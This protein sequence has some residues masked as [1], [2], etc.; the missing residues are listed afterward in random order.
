MFRAQ[1]GSHIPTLKR[2]YIP[3]NY[4]DP[5]G[6]LGRFRLN[7]CQKKLVR[8]GVC[9]GGMFRGMFRCMF[10]GMFRGMFRGTF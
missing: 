8:I 9:F 10:W 5:L 7:R 4:M 1:R 6:R 2:K 3:Y